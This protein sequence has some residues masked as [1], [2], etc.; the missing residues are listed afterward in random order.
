MSKSQKKKRIHNNTTRE[1]IVSEKHFKLIIIMSYN[2]E[3]K[4]N[5]LI[6]TMT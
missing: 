1:N 2:I 6:G 4:A 3:Q 5:S